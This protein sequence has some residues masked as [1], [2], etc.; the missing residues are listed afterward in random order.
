MRR[1]VSTGGVTLQAIS[2]TDG[3]FLAWDLDAAVRPGCLGF[4]I[5][6]RDHTA[7]EEYWITGFKTF[8]SMIPV[9]RATTQ[10][11]SHEHP[12]QSFYWGDYSAKPGHEYTYRLVPRY[13]T[14][15]RLE[16]HV[17]VEATVDVTTQ[18]PAQ[19]VHGIY[20]NRGVAASQAYTVRFGAP[21]DQLTPDKRIE[22]MQW[23]SRGLHEAIIAFIGRASSGSQAL[24]AAVYEFTE[25]GVLAAFQQA[26]VAGADVEIVYHAA[27]DSTGDA[28]RKAIADAGLD[29]SI[30]IERTHAKIAHNKFI[31]LCDR[32]QGGTL[33]PTSVWTGSTNFSIGGIFGH[34]N[35]GH[36]VRDP[37]VA[38]SFLG[39]W[40]EL[41][42]DPLV[43]PL[44]D[45]V[46][47]N[48]PFVKAS[49]PGDGMRTLFS[50]RHGT[51]PLGWY[52]TAFGG[53]GLVANITPAFGLTTPF[54][55]GLA[56]VSA[57]SPAL[58]YVLLDKKDNNQDVWSKDHRVFV[59]VGSTGG[60]DSLERWAQETLTGFNSFVPFIHT[61]VL[62]V[63]PLS[64]D[65]LVISG[66][67]NFSED[68][69]NVNDENMLVIGGDLAVADVYFTEFA[70]MFTHFYARWWASQLSH[71]A[72]TGA[73]PPDPSFLA[74][75]DTWQQP[76]FA[77]GNPK[78]LQRTLY[79]SGVDGNV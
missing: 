51:D 46:S 12:V 13:G 71:A 60:P 38:G 21:P 41:S 4:A 79:S 26:H 37:G 11:S 53:A 15:A 52:A 22:A 68:S 7:G 23:L 63:D 49:P 43:D 2:G 18:D 64:A 39:Y 44:R 72:A 77:T 29:T 57:G 74:E 32:D 30:L 67:A 40:S 58:H 17:G 55:Q 14:P 61:K 59:A 8:R 10:Y 70:R 3:V 6:R 78:S 56:G 62:L 34:S 42:G 28:N 54:E 1:R 33:T 27:A 35:V 20:F 36:E 48:S 25:P 66:S 73:A 50:P 45:W 19:G 76:Y 69:T 75:D 65:P 31:V 9:P 24:R 5:S 47:A 16:D